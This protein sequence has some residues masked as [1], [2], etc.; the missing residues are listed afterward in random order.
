MEIKIGCDIVRIKRFKESVRRGG[1]IFLNKIFSIRELA[2]NPLAEKLVGIFAAKEAV[3]KA[4][5]EE[6]QL[7]A[8]DWK[9]IEITKKTNGKPEIKLLKFNREILSCDISISHDGDYAIAVAIFMLK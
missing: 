7:K 2:G 4:L 8:G 3:I 9:K 5:G 1:E 6:L